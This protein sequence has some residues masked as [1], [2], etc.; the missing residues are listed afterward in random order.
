[1]ATINKRP[2]GKWQAT[3][4]LAGRSTS[5]TFTKRADAVKWARV[6]ETEAERTDSVSHRALAGADTANAFTLAYAL[7]H[8]ANEQVG[9]R[10]RLHALARTQVAKLRI[11]VL[12][13]D[14]FAQW[15]DQRMLDAKPSTV[16]RELSLMQTA[17]D[18]QLGEYADSPANP[19]RHLKRPRVV[20]RRERRLTDREW[21]R[22]L[23]AAG[24]CLNPLMRPLLVLARE[25]AMRRGELLSMEWRN[26][27]L[28]ACTVLLPKTKNGHARLVPLS[29]QAVAILA[30]LHRND[31]RV[32]PMTAN[33]VRLAWQRL[34]ARAGV[35][36]IRLHDLRAQAATDK[37]LDGWS[38][39]EV[40][41]LT[42][43]RDAGVLLE[44]YARLR[45]TDV[46]AKLHAQGAR[47]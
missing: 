31:E 45:A 27:D 15:R 5:K 24:E 36:D 6:V 33:A 29:P 9:E 44:R 2:S 12:T 25:T 37:L 7:R 1:M 34:R 42:G 46:V 16:V 4:R 22:L 19:V 43:H 35:A 38:V 23:D 18:R 30:K 26:V 28:E 41:V 10:W 8:L 39:A 13:L 32:L 11:N 17:I 47:E 20:D 40:Q 3:V 21:Q 14:D